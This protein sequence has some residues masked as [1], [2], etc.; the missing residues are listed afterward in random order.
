M[1]LYLTLAWLALRILG[2]VL[3]WRYRRQIYARWPALGGW[4]RARAAVCADWACACAAKRCAAGH[5]PRRS[6]RFSLPFG[7]KRPS[8]EH[9]SN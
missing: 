8:G 2:G 5:E 4:M 7:T 6:G 1:I 9:F 3:L